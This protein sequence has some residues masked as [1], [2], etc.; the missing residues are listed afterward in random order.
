MVYKKAITFKIRFIQYIY[1]GSYIVEIT[2]N[3][4]SNEE[5]TIKEIQIT[6]E[7]GEISSKELIMYYLFRIAKYDQD[8]P[9]INSILE[10]NPD[11]IIIAEALDYERKRTGPRGP[12]HG[13]PVFLKDNIDTKDSMHTSSGTIALEY[14]KSIEDAFLVKKLCW[15]SYIKQNKYDGIS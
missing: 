8:G 9:K 15:C 7:N 6:M 2:F 10:I 3:K 12:L 5:I 11:A 1:K 13:I 14:N 4:F